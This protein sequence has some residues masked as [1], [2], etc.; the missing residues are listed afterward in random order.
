MI[1]TIAAKELRI[2]FGSPLAWITLGVLQAVLAWLFLNQ[3]DAF[4]ALQAQL[5]MLAN[6]P[7]VTE[8][9]VAPL[10]GAAAM[11]LLVVTPVLAMRLIAEE[12]RNHTLPLL[13]SAP[14]SLSEIVLGKFLGLWAFLCLIIM[15]TLFMALSLLA[16]GQ[17]DF[18]LL[19]AN[20]SG[21]VLL[22][23]CLAALGLYFSCLTAH[24][25]VAAISGIGASL[26]LWLLD[27]VLKDV[28]PLQVLSLLQHF[29]RISRGFLNSADVAYFL[30]FTA[31]FL[32]LAV[33]RLD[34]DRVRG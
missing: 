4:L 13:F 12:R 25:A 33:R 26:G 27:I 29:E 32:M 23:A 15:L 28:G 8:M 24:P 34:Q 17:L 11:L 3:V 21:L 9:V 5:A 14:V 31:T 19:F 6:P 7:G 20:L 16:G 22:T 10:F 30:L 2:L 1:Y 18:G